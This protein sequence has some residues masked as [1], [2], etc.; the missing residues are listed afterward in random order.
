MAWRA[1]SEVLL[2]NRATRRDCSR[3]CRHKEHENRQGAK[4]PRKLSN[5]TRIAR[6]SSYL[7]AR[8]RQVRVTMILASWRLGGSPESLA[9]RGLP[10]Q[11]Q[12]RYGS[13]T[14]AKSRSGT[15]TIGVGGSTVEAELAKLSSMRGNVPPIT[16]ADRAQRI[17]RAQALM[18]EAGIAALW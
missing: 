2:L 3:L 15:M 1:P 7:D 13:G 9:A 5:A 16:D 12:P 11:A 14:T 18:R 10:A 6:C 17:E 8:M 4:T